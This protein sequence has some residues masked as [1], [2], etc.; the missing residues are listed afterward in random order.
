MKETTKYKIAIF[1]KEK[2]SW[3]N[4]LSNILI[5]IIAIIWLSVDYGKSEPLMAALSAIFSGLNIIL[6]SCDAKITNYLSRAIH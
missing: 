6:N 2:R 1:I 3:L 4:V 5:L